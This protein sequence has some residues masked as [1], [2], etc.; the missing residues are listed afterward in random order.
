M[1]FRPFEFIF[2]SV[3]VALYSQDVLAADRS[4]GIVDSSLLGFLW[5]MRHTLCSTRCRSSAVKLGK[6]CAQRLH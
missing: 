5:V 1:P 2:V 3:P 4:G 6:T